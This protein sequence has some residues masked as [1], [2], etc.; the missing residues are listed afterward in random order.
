ML[1]MYV[2]SERKTGNC[3]QE[4]SDLR[5]EKGGRGAERH[6]LEEVN[7]QEGGNQD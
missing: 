5:E 4:G 7:Q 2:R 6:Y 3:K 1:H